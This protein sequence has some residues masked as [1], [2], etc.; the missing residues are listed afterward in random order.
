MDARNKSKSPLDGRIPRVP[1]RYFVELRCQGNVALAASV[2]GV[3][4]S[5]LSRW[6]HGTGPRDVNSKNRGRLIASGIEPYSI[7]EV[8]EARKFKDLGTARARAAARGDN[9]AVAGINETLHHMFPSFPSSPPFPAV[10]PTIEL[11]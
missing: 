7:R 4:I 10:P 3:H 1:I 8:W 5:Q 2:I 9:A 11:W 6:L